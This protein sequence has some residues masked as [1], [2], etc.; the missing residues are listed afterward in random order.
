MFINYIWVF[1]NV[2][3]LVMHLEAGDSSSASCLATGARCYHVSLF[4]YICFSCSW[5]IKQV[6]FY[7][8]FSMLMQFKVDMLELGPGCIT[9]NQVHE[10][11]LCITTTQMYL[12]ENTL[13]AWYT[14]FLQTVTYF[15]SQKKKKKVKPHLKTSCS[16]IMF[17]SSRHILCLLQSHFPQNMAYYY[18]FHQSSM[19]NV[20]QFHTS[21]PPA[22]YWIV[23]FK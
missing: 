1:G 15:N 12:H 16:I 6:L 4:L 8:V 22:L 9:L 3:E 21:Y 14:Q 5:S 10:H 20:Q 2:A 19:Y 23:G 13:C 11:T 18:H 7:L 17:W